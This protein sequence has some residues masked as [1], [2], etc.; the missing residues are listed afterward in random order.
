VSNLFTSLCTDLADPVERLHAIH[1]VTGAAK[2]VHL[3]LGPEML[4]DWSEWAPPRPYAWFMRQYSRLNLADRHNPPINLVVSNVP[5]PKEPLYIAGAEL[6]GIWSVGP[7][8]EGVGLNVTVWSYRDR[9]HVG[10]IGCREHWADLHVVTDGMAAALAT[11]VATA[12]ADGSDAPSYSD[13]HVRG[14]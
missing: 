9:V 8:V 2:E 13:P 1:A 14:G 10:V 4:A 6:V 12:S 5:G 3:L 7:V 11:L